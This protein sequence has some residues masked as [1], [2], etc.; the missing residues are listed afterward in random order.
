M[1]CTGY[2]TEVDICMYR[3]FSL[4]VVL[5]ATMSYKT[6]AGTAATAAAGMVLVPVLLYGYL[7]VPYHTIP[8]L[9]PL[10]LV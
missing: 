4:W 7:L 8:V 10:L 6:A 3:S 1:Y 2:S 5:L 9:V